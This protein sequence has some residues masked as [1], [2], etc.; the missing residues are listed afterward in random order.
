MCPLRFLKPGANNQLSPRQ[1]LHLWA[2]VRA[3]PSGTRTNKACAVMSVSSSSHKS[4]MAASVANVMFVNAVYF[5]NHK[6]YEGYTPGGMNYRCISH[7]Y[8]AF[9]T[10]GEDGAVLVSDPLYA[11]MAKRVA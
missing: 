9:A 7:V 6:I 11:L 1:V 4:R 8:Y 5:P 10:I 2:L 3:T